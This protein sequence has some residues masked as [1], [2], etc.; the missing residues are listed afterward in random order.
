MFVQV[1]VSSLFSCEEKRLRPKEKFSADAPR[2]EAR[3]HEGI[4]TTAFA[5][6]AK[7]LAVYEGMSLRSRRYRAGAN[8]VR[9]AAL[10]RPH[11]GGG[12]PPRRLPPC[13][14]ASRRGRVKHLQDG[15]RRIG[16]RFVRHIARVPFVSAHHPFGD[17]PKAP[18]MIP[19]RGHA[20]KA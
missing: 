15:F 10:R 18:C 14:R 16:E 2:F 5:E 3:P 1:G 8:G 20:S 9:G 6:L 19:S 12:S 17:Q 7:G 11:G 13:T 4:L